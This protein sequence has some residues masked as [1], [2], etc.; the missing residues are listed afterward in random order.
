MEIPKDSN[1]RP[2]RSSLN[3]SSSSSSDQ[4]PVAIANHDWVKRQM[5]LR[6]KEYTEPLNAEIKIITWNVNGKRLG[7]DL[8]RLLLE[9]ADP[10]IYA[11]GYSFEIQ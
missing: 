4:G 8:A 5:R 2:R 11:V 9:T 7:E 10:G 6:R 1:G 3:S